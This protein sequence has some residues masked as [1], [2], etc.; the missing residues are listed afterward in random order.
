M[1]HITKINIG[2]LVV[3]FL[4]VSFLSSCVSQ[5]KIKYLQSEAEKQPFVEK[6]FKGAPIANY[7]VKEGDNLYIQV[8]SED[9]NAREYFMG[10][11][12]TG[13]LNNNVSAYLN[14]Y[15]VDDNGNIDFPVTGLVKVSD[16]NVDQIRE[17]IQNKVNEYFTAKTTII[18][19]LVNYSITILGEV[20]RPGKYNIYQDYLNIFEALG[21]AGDLTDFAQ[22]K[23]VK[24]LRQT[25]T[26]YRMQVLD[27]TKDEILTSDYYQIMPNDILYIEPLKIK[28]FGFASFPY[29][30]LF[31]T[32]T[33]TLLILN[34]L[35][36]K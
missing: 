22:R 27:L 5:K 28:Q 15:K 3:L 10:F 16:L 19:K 24:L 12:P 18:V 17:K 30:I 11:R 29:S 35:N 34:F 20:R 13:Y 32:I 14:S 33:T 36:K 4:I 7:L 2:R 25:E 6:T 26:G 1:K 9:P 31:S 21:M 23:K 8:S